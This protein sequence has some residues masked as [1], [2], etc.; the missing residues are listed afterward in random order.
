MWASLL[1]S[2]FSPLK[3]EQE[4]P[5]DLVTETLSQR[6]G[7][8]V[9][10]EDAASVFIDPAGTFY[11]IFLERPLVLSQNLSTP[12]HCPLLPSVSA[13]TAP[14]THLLPLPELVPLHSPVLSLGLSHHWALF[15]AVAAVLV[16]DLQPQELG[17]SPS[18]V[19]HWL[20]DF[21]KALTS[22]SCSI[23]CGKEADNGAL[24]ILDVL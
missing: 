5:P 6:N 21:D 12:L 15:S 24:S 9:G 19:T 14:V 13:S 7:Q 16:W 10:W 22:L 18:V 1:A 8:V 20:L 2:L 23:S 11:Q 4:A 17:S 3:W